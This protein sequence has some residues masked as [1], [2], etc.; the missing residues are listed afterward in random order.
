MGLVVMCHNLSPGLTY[1]EYLQRYYFCGKEHKREKLIYGVGFICEHLWFNKVGLL[2]LDSLEKRF[3]VK[4]TRNI[5]N[6]F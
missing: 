5:L 1:T 3:T 6:I 2:L 4:V